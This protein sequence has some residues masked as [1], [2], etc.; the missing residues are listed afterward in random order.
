MQNGKASKSRADLNRYTLADVIGQAGAWLHELGYTYGDGA[1]QVESRPTGDLSSM[2]WV[3]TSLRRHRSA[4]PRSTGS[5]PLAGCCTPPGLDEAVSVCRPLASLDL[6]G[7]H[8]R[9]APAAQFCNLV[10]QFSFA[11]EFCSLLLQPSFAI[12]F[13]NRTLQPSST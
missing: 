4:L 9:G 13:C 8:R 7:V 3:Y 10:L 12:E 1:M 2:D 5:V 11:P 6:Q